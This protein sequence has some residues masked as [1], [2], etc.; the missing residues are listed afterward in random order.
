MIGFGPTGDLG[1][2]TFYTK[3]N[4][5]IVFFLKAPPK[6]PPTPYQLRNMAVF[7]VAAQL[8]NGLDPQ[9][10]ANW[11]K[12]QQLANLGITSYNF[13]VYY[14]ATNDRSAV[15]TI[16]RQTGLELLAG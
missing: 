7:E 2:Y 10:K 14:I 3:A 11:L 12:V 5:T 1:P 9:L 6:T 16:E 15:R 8:W 13:W 4:G